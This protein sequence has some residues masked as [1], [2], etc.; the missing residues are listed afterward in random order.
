MAKIKKS[1]ML[2]IIAEALELPLDALTEDSDMGHVEEWD[3]VGHLS[4]LVALDK[5]LGGAVGSLQ[6]MATADSIAKVWQILLEH[7]LA[8]EA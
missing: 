3:S 2:S 6:D 4:M 8:D 1:E 5:A 7:G